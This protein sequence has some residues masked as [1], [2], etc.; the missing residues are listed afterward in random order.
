MLQKL[1][2]AVALALAFCVQPAFNLSAADA[3]GT[4]GRQIRIGLAL[5]TLAEERWHRDLNNMVLQAKERGLDLIVQVTMNDQNQQNFNIEQLITL[6]VDVLI[7]APHDSYGMGRIVEH[8]QN[9]GIKV[10]CYDRLI[11]NADIDLYVSY[12]NVAV[13]QLQG[14][15]LAEKVKRGNFLILSGPRYDSNARFFKAGAMMELQPLI[16]SGDVKVLLDQDVTNW[17][18]DATKE[19]VE[20]A[21]IRHPDGIDAILAPNDGMAAGAIAALKQN[22]L[23]G[24][25]VV[26]GQDA[27]V[28]AVRR[29]IE[30]SQ[31]MTVFKDLSKEV[32]VAL[33][34]AVILASGGDITKLTQGQTINNEKHD[35]PVILLQ[36]VELDKT[37]VNEVLLEA[38]HIQREVVLE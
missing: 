5:P 15:Y 3:P 21:L 23:I 14:K 36:P 7:I 10:I 33:D 26:T 9:S 34:A 20:T 1:C 29:V 28:N 4:R 13:G 25:I 2:A 17:S 38:G 19:L 31:A 30:G 12:D 18:P 11:M 24:K 27:D 16:D 6:G 35:V 22:N 37:N 8:A 32:K